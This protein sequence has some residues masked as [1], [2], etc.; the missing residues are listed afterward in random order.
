MVR[1]S[2]KL[3]SSLLAG[4]VLGGLLSATATAQSGGS[5]MFGSNSPSN[6]SAAGMA[7]M[8][9]T[10]FNGMSGGLGGSGSLFGNSAFGNNGMTGGMNN[11]NGTGANGRTNNGANQNQGNFVGR[12]VNPNQFIGGN[13]MTG[14]GNQGQ[15]NQRRQG[16]L[17]NRIQNNDD[18]QGENAGRN[19]SG[20]AP[21]LR[22]RQQIG[23]NV[24]RPPQVQRESQL[25]TRF[26]KVTERN[27]SMKGI[28]LVTDDTGAVVLQGSVP[29]ESVAKLAVK[30]V[31]FEPGVTSVR[32]E[33][34]YPGIPAE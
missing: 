30:L 17:R 33:L 16:G 34:I 2:H 19:N 11:R 32:S 8:G 23:F 20:Q 28:T 26:A 18:F 29:S 31:R 6:R 27:A 24:P 14:T 1:R 25:R 21:L 4:L 7:S 5:S 10:N 13:N 9:G 22:P 12:N 15:Q 3:L